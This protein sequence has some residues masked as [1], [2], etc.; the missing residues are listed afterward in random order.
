M[1]CR[2]SCVIWQ[3]PSIKVFSIPQKVQEPFTD[4]AASRMRKGQVPSGQRN[5]HWDT[6][7]ARF[8]SLGEMLAGA[9]EEYAG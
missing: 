6:H 2:E 3:E 7:D 1:E 5:Q 9:S 8:D 4:N